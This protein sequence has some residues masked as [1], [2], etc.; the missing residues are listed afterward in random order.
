M[1]H[2]TLMLLL[3]SLLLSAPNENEDSLFTDPEDGAF[4]AS[5][6]LSQAY[7]FL[8][9]PTIITEPAVGFGAAVGLLYLHDNFEGKESSSGRNV[10]PSISGIIVAATENGTKAGG[11]FHIGHWKEDTIRTATVLLRYD[12]NIDLYTT[13]GTKLGMN[14]DGEYFYQSAKFRIMESN[15]FLGADYTYAKMT[16]RFGDNDDSLLPLNSENTTASAS[17]IADYDSRDNTFSPNEGF[18]LNAQTSFFRKELGSDENFER[19]RVQ[20]LFYNKIYDDLF[21]DLKVNFEGV[22]DDDTPF[23]M[24]PFV[25]LRGIPMMRYQGEKTMS[26]E[27]Q[28]R[29]NFKPRWSALVFGGI[30]KAYGQDPFNP[31][32]DNSFSQ[33]QNRYT[34]GLGF[35]YLIAK[36]YGLRMGIDIASSQEDEAIYLQFGTAWAGL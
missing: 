3:T 11:G 19:Y 16:T 23:Y 17:I 35:R 12:V 18:L 1:R 6:Y 10:P 5:N 15:L 30:G 28:L 25:N 29:W 36:K 20:G 27:L 14:G 13:N 4:D 22:S 26:N 8:P 31:F 34:K 2:I 33:A 21:L 24:Y 9:V 7:G 32:I